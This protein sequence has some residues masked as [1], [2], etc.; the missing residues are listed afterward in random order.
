MDK[1]LQ[2]LNIILFLSNLFIEELGKE[3]ARKNMTDAELLDDAGVQVQANQ[4][5]ALANL[6]KYEAAPE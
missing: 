3:S 6:A 4:V 5:M 1:S 2:I